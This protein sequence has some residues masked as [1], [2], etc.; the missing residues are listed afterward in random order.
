MLI[1]TL[2][3]SSL[4]ARGVYQT[5]KDFLD[6]VYDNAPPKSKSMMLVGGLRKSVEKILEH[7]YGSL[8][9]RYWKKDETTAWILEEIGKVEPITFGVEIKDNQI[10]DIKV[11]EFREI[12]GWE[13][14]YPGFRKQFEG[15]SL[16]GMKLDRD[17][18]GISGATLSVWAMTSI[19][20]LS[21]FL[22]QYVKNK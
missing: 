10:Q 7:P 12:R 8:R 4:H 11:L 2:L 22:D 14:K 9:I 3:A 19:A 16:E 20:E 6:E 17:V 1:V 21:L 13:V 5:N 15:A 18:D